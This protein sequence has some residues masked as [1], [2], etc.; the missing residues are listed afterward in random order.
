MTLK[1]SNM[2]WRK[3]AWF[4]IV[5]L[6]FGGFVLTTS[7]SGYGL[8]GS[9]VAPGHQ[10]LS[11]LG[12]QGCSICHP[13][14]AGLARQLPGGSASMDRACEVCH[15]GH[16]IHHP[17]QLI[18]QTKRC[19]ACHRE[20]HGKEE[21]TYVP[22]HLCT[23]C[24]ARL[25]RQ[26]GQQPTCLNVT[27]WPCHPEFAPQ[28]QAFAVKPR[29]VDFF[30]HKGHLRSE[31]VRGPNGSLQ[32]LKCS[33]CHQPDKDA[34]FMQP[35][36]YQESCA[37]CHLLSVQLTGVKE[38]SA[39]AEF[40]KQPARH[41]QVKDVRGD[42]FERLVR[43]LGQAPEVLQREQPLQGQRLI[44][45]V[46]SRVE[47]SRWE[48]IERQVKALDR[49]LFVHGGG[50]RSC[51]QPEDSADGVPVFNVPG[52]PSHS[53]ARAFFNHHAHRRTECVNCHAVMSSGFPQDVKTPA[54]QI[55]QKCHTEGPL[56][57]V[58][59]VRATCVGCH[60]YHPSCQKNRELREFMPQ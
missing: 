16:S 49:Q 56:R 13:G 11:S 22:D 27:D 37:P 48:W 2:F 46:E 39:I 31:G 8:T 18:S 1:N 40:R 28:R 58:N 32:V 23:S 3:R 20:H 24:H 53:L 15:K 45:R 4:L 50:C 41:A 10:G 21:L 59:E 26:D 57:R 43:L 17:Q 47:D 5:G 44:H 19:T 29:Q 55:C 9:L 33:A 35:A 25:E 38:G 36:R 14:G 51:H 7:I 12:M 30:S 54:I 34:R 52:I 6:G 60:T 42:L